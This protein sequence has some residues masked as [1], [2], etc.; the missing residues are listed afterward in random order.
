MTTLSYG[1]PVSLAAV[2]RVW[3]VISRNPQAQ[4]RHIACELNVCPATVTAALRVLRKA[5]YVTRPRPR[6]EAADVH[7]FFG[8]I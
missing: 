4:V 7:V 3:A 6:A 8:W 5:G 1:T 2:R